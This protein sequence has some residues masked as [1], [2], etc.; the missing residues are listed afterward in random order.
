MNQPHQS[1]ATHDQPGS[2]RRLWPVAL[3]RRDGLIERFAYHYAR[4]RQRPRRWRAQLARR[5]ALT[6]AG[7]ALLLAL[8]P[9]LP[10]LTGVLTPV[11][12]YALATAITVADGAVSVVADGQCALIE[13]IDNA[14]DKDDGLRHAD[15]AAGNPNGAD[16]IELPPGGSFTLLAPRPA[17]N[18]GPIG[19]PWISTALTINGHGATIRRSSAAP[20]FRV[21]A[22]GKQ[23]NLTLNDTTISG[24]HLN[25]FDAGIY[26]DYGGAGIFNEGSL[27]LTGVTVAD[28][29]VTSFYAIGGGIENRGQLTMSGSTLVGNMVAGMAS[30]WGGGLINRAAGSVVI[31]DSVISGNLARAAIP[32]GYAY[33]GGLY[34]DGGAL[35]LL[36][37]TV[38]DNEANA[39]TFAGGGGLESSGPATIAG[40]AI[41]AN[42][43]VSGDGEYAQATGGGLGN[44]DEMT[45]VNSTISG[46]EADQFGGGLLNLSRLTIV[47]ST[48]T[49][50]RGAGVVS[51]CEST[52]DSVSLVL[53]RSLISGNVGGEVSSFF[54][55]YCPTGVVA[56]NFNLFG[57]SG[58]EGLIGFNAGPSDIL[59]SAGLLSIIGALG[60]NGGPTLTHDLP[61]GSP[62]RDRA[63][64][65][66]CL[67]APVDGVDQRGL[68]RNY[69]GA[70]GPG[71]SECD[72]GALEYQPAL[73]T[74]T[75]TPTATA[76]ATATPTATTTPTVTPTGTLVATATP[77]AT[78]PAPDWEIYLPVVIGE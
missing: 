53:R 19:L 43:A 2:P 64:S 47:N 65:A 8:N 24:G 55:Q 66:D 46:N 75:P 74:P 61:P 70:A 36:D 7:A 16:T 56:D 38:T 41:T 30:G 1:P 49:D 62:A 72:I 28:N 35:T 10:D 11:R 23:G 69:N 39:D 5:A 20:H 40:S 51:S 3:L 54:P 29:T 67:D 14:N 77:T 9:A 44:S 42:R 73:D 60:D 59:P 58:I 48:I 26:A 63:P 68:P 18:V 4:L 22:V 21:L 52:S 33:G 45:I 37:T 15:C 6:L 12:S 50:N 31:M 34:N 71:D 78:R 13:A 25:D 17:G 32:D 76:T 27:T 57:H